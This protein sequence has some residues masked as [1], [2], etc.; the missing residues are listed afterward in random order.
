M[1]GFTGGLESNI[2]LLRDVP[3]ELQDFLEHFLSFDQLTKCDLYY[4]GL[5]ATSMNEI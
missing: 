3:S 4:L 1:C 5:P 2:Y